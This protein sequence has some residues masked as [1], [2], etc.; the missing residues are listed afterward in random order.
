[1]RIHASRQSEPASPY[2]TTPRGQ[3]TAGMAVALPPVVSLPVSTDLRRVVIRMLGG[4]ELE[5]GRTEG[6]EPAV[7]LA[8]DT[9]QLVEDAQQAGEWPELGDRFLR[10]D[11]IVSIDIQRTT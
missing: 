8:R 9:I 3:G 11:A 10:P 4:E 6:R 7:R 2:R 5:V 1:M